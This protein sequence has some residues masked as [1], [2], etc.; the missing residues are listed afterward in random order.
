LGVKPSLTT[1]FQN[2]KGGFSMEI[3]GKGFM[4]VPVIIFVLGIVVS[5]AT[6]S[7]GVERINEK[8]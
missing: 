6:A 1:S 4:I 3:M 7:I 8:K 2:T 5:A